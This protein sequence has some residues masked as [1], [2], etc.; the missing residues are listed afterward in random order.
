M[1]S[2]CERQHD[3]STRI[4]I[5]SEFPTRIN[6]KTEFPH[7]LA[8]PLWTAHPKE[9]KERTEICVRIPMSTQRD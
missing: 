3:R 2:P 7:N 9:L 8:S 4:N 5:E 6:I 1:C